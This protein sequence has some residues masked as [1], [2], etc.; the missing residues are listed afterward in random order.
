MFQGNLEKKVK[1]CFME[2]FL[3]VTRMFQA[4]LKSDET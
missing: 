4:M 1:G 2:K 3:D